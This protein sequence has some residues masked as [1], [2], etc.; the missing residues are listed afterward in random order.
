LAVLDE[1]TSGGSR[2]EF[3]EDEGDVLVSVPNEIHCEMTRFIAGK[4]RTI[5]IWLLR[6]VLII[7]MRQPIVSHVSL[8]SEEVGV[9]HFVAR[10][11]KDMGSQ[12]VPIVPKVL[13][14]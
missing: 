5:L 8:K 7:P 13:N 1:C 3:R 6:Q 10:N 14:T 4:E 12:F 2:N 9:F 11:G